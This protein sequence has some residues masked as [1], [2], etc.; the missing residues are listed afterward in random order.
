MVEYIINIFVDAIIT[1]YAV[2][3]LVQDFVLAIAQGPLQEII[4]LP[5]DA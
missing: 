1:E 2:A 5:R 3:Q 4:Q